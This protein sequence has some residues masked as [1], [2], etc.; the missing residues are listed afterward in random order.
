VSDERPLWRR[1]FE[2]WLLVAAR[3]GEAQTL[4]IV[5]LA[6][7]VV[8]G[9]V[10]VAIRLGRGDPLRKQALRAPGSAWLEADSTSTPDVE[11]AKRLF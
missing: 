11:R 2:G 4:V 1:L 10:A 8:V 5:G 9:P 6:Y 3:F 7:A